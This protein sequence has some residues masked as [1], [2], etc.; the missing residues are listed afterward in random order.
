MT[1]TQRR[2]V[3]DS[4]RYA[5]LRDGVSNA[6]LRQLLSAVNAK[7]E[8]HVSNERI[9]ALL[10]EGA[11]APEELGLRVKTEDGFNVAQALEDL[12]KAQKERADN[13][14]DNAE[15]LAHH[16]AYFRDLVWKDRYDAAHAIEPAQRTIRDGKSLAGANLSEALTK[17]VTCQYL[18]EVLQ[19]PVDGVCDAPPLPDYWKPH[20]RY[21]REI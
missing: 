15:A 1:N 8:L 6:E 3:H 5:M 4:E 20:S 21:P 18:K 7:G 12:K 17:E 19:Q 13:K 9:A 16:I 14:P 10:V 11:S 2:L